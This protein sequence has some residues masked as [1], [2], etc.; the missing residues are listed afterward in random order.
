MIYRA[1]FSPMMHS[2]YQL[3]NPLEFTNRESNG[4]SV[5][6]AANW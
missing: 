2:D 6:Y 5:L 3:Q 1:S 4:F